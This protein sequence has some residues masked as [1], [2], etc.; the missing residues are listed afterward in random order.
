MTFADVLS[1]DGKYNPSL[2][3]RDSLLFSLFIEFA[4]FWLSF[5]DVLSVLSSS[6]SPDIALFSVV[7]LV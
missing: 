7:V 3:G 5:I 1:C 2:S 4:G 6:G